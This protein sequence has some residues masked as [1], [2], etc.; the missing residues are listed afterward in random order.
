MYVTEEEEDADKGRRGWEWDI[1]N[2]TEK[3][4]SDG[5][6]VEENKFKFT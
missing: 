6:D 3:V 2:V 1:E 5:D 4:G